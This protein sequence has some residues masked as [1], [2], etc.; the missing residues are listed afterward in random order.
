MKM[1]RGIFVTQ[2]RVLF[3]FIFKYDII[4]IIVVEI[5]QDIFPMHSL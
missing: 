2:T 1:H 3:L 4:Y 5:S